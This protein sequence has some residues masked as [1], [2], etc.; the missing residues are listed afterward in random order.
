MF[1][2]LFPISFVIKC[3][4]CIQAWSSGKSWK[5]KKDSL[6]G[7]FFFYTSGAWNRRNTI[8]KRGIQKTMEEI[9]FLFYDHQDYIIQLKGNQRC[10]DILLVTTS[11]I[12]MLSAPQEPSS[13]CTIWRSRC[14]LWSRLKET[15]NCSIRL[16]L[17]FE[18]SVSLSWCILVVKSLGI[19]SSHTKHAT[20][21]W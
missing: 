13:V 1:L 20:K 10:S 14:L 9:F 11:F 3:R 15:V 6:T 7:V 4:V 18:G 19:Y 2:G 5:G 17:L 21:G 16:L 12:G 8:F